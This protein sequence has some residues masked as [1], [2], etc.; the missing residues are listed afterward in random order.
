MEYAIFV[1]VVTIMTALYVRHI[2]KKYEQAIAFQDFLIRVLTI[3]LQKVDPEFR[4]QDAERWLGEG[5]YPEMSHW[6][7]SKEERD[8]IGGQQ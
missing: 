6:H 7:L 2:T 8:V 3:R 5:L 1:V 4:V